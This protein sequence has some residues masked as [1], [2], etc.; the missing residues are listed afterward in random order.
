MSLFRVGETEEFMNKALTKIMAAGGLAAV[1]VTGAFA[2]TAAPTTR[3]L[4]ETIFSEHTGEP[5]QDFFDPE[6]ASQLNLLQVCDTEYKGTKMALVLT[7]SRSDITAIGQA[8][9][10]EK[11]RGLSQDDL[12][13]AI[14][15]LPDDE[16]RAVTEAYTEKMT[17]VLTNLAGM[18]ADMSKDIHITEAVAPAIMPGGLLDRENAMTGLKREL[19]EISDEIESKAGISILFDAE[20]SDNPALDAKCATL[21]K[22]PAP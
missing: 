18:L 15:A 21:K 5:Q 9:L 19:Q 17:A 6:D 12:V 16:Q 22:A 8:A 7:P 20:I 13:Q 11:L 2:Q 14:A 3:D 4:K 10:P 1:T